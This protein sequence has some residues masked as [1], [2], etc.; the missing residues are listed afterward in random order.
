MARFLA[1]W[2]G[3]T[4]AIAAAVFA[5]NLV[6][7]PYGI[8]GSPRM[9][10]INRDKV[11]AVDWSRLA[12]PYLLEKAQP[13]AVV[14]GTSPCD[15]G[16]DPE[17]AAWPAHLRPVFNM[18]MDGGGLG[19]LLIDERDVFAVAAPKLLVICA[20]LEDTV[21]MPPVT[22]V[23]GADAPSS[24]P[25]TDG[26]LRL[27]VTPSGL[28]NPDYRRARFQDALFAL[29]SMQ[30]TIDSLHTLLAQSDPYRNFESPLGWLSA[31]KFPLWANT[32]GFYSLVSTKDHDHAAKFLAWSRAPRF[33]VEELAEMIAVARD[34]GAEVVVLILPNYADQ[35]EIYRQLG[36]IGDYERWKSRVT[37][38]VAEAARARGGT[39][40]WDFSGFSHYTTERLPVPG[41]HT[42]R[43]RWFW[44][45]I[46]F[47]P[48]LG[49]LMIERIT[50]DGPPDLGLVLTPDNLAQQFAAFR[51]AQREWVAS[52][53]RDVE[54]VA[55][56]IAEARR[57]ACRAAH[58]ANCP[59]RVAGSR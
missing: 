30:A 57:E 34:H 27:R 35:M 46:H 17:S 55:G 58:P 45:Q 50:G 49:S 29:F 9:L 28:P 33:Y 20:T 15:V 44:E 37:D 1:I 31:G 54:R 13:G 2:L 3:A 24:D 11:A 14:F 59:Q 41:D 32:E 22:P 25:D 38:I 51:A 16:F 6:V 10:G 39:T 7:D 42:T 4:L 5:L 36:L 18:T 21:V 43:L 53:P 26:T 12:K 8:F 23:D 52:H 56:I 40:L 48:E 19:E 47:Q